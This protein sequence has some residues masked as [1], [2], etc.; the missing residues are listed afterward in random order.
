MRIT[1]GLNFNL[2]VDLSLLREGTR[3][4]STG[5]LLHQT[6]PGLPMGEEPNF[7]RSKDGR[8]LGLSA[9]QFWNRPAPIFSNGH[10]PE[11]KQ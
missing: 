7:K 2:D 8:R 1:I 5:R 9:W 6:N 3:S 11:E 10:V 4:A